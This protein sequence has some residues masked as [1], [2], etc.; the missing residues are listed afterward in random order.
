[1]DTTS[2]ER[3]GAS[4][5]DFAARAVVLVEGVSDQLALE[6]LAARRGR[7]LTV[8]GVAVVPMG[9]SKNI[10]R[11]LDTYGPAGL[12]L[13]LAGLCDDAE[14]DDYVRALERAG[15]G[16]NLTRDDLERLG[17]FVCMRDLEDELI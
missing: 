10:R 2:D 9:G 7:D 15:F 17:F 16:T 4:R 3:P 12:G 11:F 8:E 1:M 14:I 6:T 13:R 5:A